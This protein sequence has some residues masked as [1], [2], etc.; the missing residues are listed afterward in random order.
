ML[1]TVTFFV[2]ERQMKYLAG[3]FFLFYS[4]F[5][6]VKLSLER[7]FIEDSLGNKYS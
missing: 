4:I 3:A 2:F 5:W 1:A 7:L 6:R